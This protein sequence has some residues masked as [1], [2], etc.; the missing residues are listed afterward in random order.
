MRKFNSVKQAQRFLNTHAAVYN[1]FNLG[2]HYQIIL[3]AMDP[4]PQT[5]GG[6][7]TIC[8]FIQLTN[9]LVSVLSGLLVGV[10]R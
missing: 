3:F 10:S 9:R 7:V 8:D 4:C 2:R 6:S 1:L 5:G